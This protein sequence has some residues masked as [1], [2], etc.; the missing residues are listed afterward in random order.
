MRPGFCFCAG[1][2]GRL[3]RHP[4]VGGGRERNRRRLVESH[5][6]A[7]FSFLSFFF[8]CS[9]TCL[10]FSFFLLVFFSSLLFSSFFSPFPS[11][12]SSSSRFCSAS[13]VF[14]A[15][16]FFLLFFF[17]GAPMTMF[18][19][20]IL[21]VLVLRMSCAEGTVINFQSGRTMAAV[22]P[23]TRD[24]RARTPTRPHAHTPWNEES[25]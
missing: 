4:D 15:F 9:F 21:R 3:F 23:C 20:F 18:R 5:G 12:P 8:F 10:L 14:H 11:C 6:A 13:C 17:H 7:V 1:G 22:R 19:V 25:M 16:L 24:V 2:C